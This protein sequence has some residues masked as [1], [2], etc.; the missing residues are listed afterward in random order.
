M[1]DRVVILVRL[2]PDHKQQIEHIAKDNRRSTV[3]EVQVALEAHVK[4]Q[5]SSPQAGA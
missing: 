4:A 2:P 5:A 1:D 3:K